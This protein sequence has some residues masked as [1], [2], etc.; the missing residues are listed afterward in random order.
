MVVQP[1]QGFAAAPQARVGRDHFRDSKPGTQSPAELPERAIGNAGHR[2]QYQPV[3]EFV[4][5]D[6][7]RVSRV[8]DR[9]RILRIRGLRFQTGI[10]V[11]G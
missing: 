5:T 2:G 8:V 9:G 3:V 1:A 10:I 7:H 11:T 6:L 4:G